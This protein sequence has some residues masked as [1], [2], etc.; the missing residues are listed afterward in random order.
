M[1]GFVRHVVHP[2]RLGLLI[3]GLL[4]LGLLTEFALRL[5][6]LPDALFDP[7]PRNTELLDRHGKPL[8]TRAAT[9]DGYARP[10]VEAALPKALVDATLAAEDKRFYR[11]AGV[12]WLA[13]LR[14]VTSI[15][16][17]GRFT[18]GGS[19][20]T[21]QL[22]KLAQP[23]PR[24]FRTKLLEAVQALRL[25]QVWGKEH[26]LCEYLNRLDY[27]NRQIG[28]DQAARFYFGKPVRHL[29]TGEAA[30][31]A[32][33]PQRPSWLN[34]LQHLDRAHRRRQWI[35]D[36]MRIDEA[37]T[38][39]ECERERAKPVELAVSPRAFNAPHFTALALP[40]TENLPSPIRTTLDLDLQ[41]ESQRILRGRLLALRDHN[42]RHGAIVVI[43]N[44]TGAV[45]V[46]VG[47]PDYFSADGGRVNGA[48][49]TRSPGSALKPFL[50]QL[51]LEHGWSPDS[52][53]QDVP[54]DF[55]TASGLYR[56]VN[57]DRRHQGP[58]R[59][60]EALA[61]SRN[62]PAVRLLQ[63]LGGAEVFQRRL[64]ELGLASLT[65][66]ADHYGLGLALGN[67]EVRL[68][69]LAN[70]YA[71]LARLGRYLPWRLLEEASPA[72]AVRIC[73]EHA[74][75]QIADVLADDDARAYA[76]GLDSPLRFR[77]PVACK[78][79]T[80]SDFRDNWA[81]GYTPEFTV[82][83]WVG[84]VDASPMRQVSGVTGAGPVMHAVM[85]HLHT[86]FGTGWY[87]RPSGLSAPPRK[88]A[89]RDAGPVAGSWRIISPVDGTVFFL[90]PDL[91]N[92]GGLIPLRTSGVAPVTWRSDS[93]ECGVADGA[94]VARLSPGEHELTAT[95]ARTGEL[96][97]TRILV[98][99]L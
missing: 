84:N 11:H 70:A 87:E 37:L 68:L 26:I 81:F 73:S 32:G 39:A 67:A 55:P 91:P 60:R 51:A 56:P 50:Y 77:F 94:A 69:E 15:L 27:G 82:G 28:C 54:T 45:R 89:L 58:V 5:V 76:F 21:Q 90:D 46:L 22:V 40:L 61:N 33:L 49:V 19:T 10:V 23:R 24:T 14:A 42:V 78:T 59:F 83:V 41:R 65:R 36:R 47:S 30:L 8:L 71:C 74:A 6:P 86:R 57:Y 20:I 98:K 92:E 31:L 9:D 2:R 52:L 66:P 35:L 96:R 3:L 79:G 43:E 80:S 88:L 7:P 34:P 1:K 12:D 18:S 93:L 63:D 16:R 75:W 38:A 4:S 64:H 48:W 13:S 97:A 72:V 85:A 44:E 95:D 99:R 62:V 25:E 17:H 29:D 53:L